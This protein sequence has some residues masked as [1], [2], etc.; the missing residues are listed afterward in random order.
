MAPRRRKLSKD[1]ERK[2]SLSQKEI[3]LILA[4]INDIIEDD[5]REEYSLSFAPIKI[6]IDKINSHYIQTGYTED[7][8][9]NFSLYLKYLKKFKSDYEI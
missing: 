1:F 8:E 3:E 9:K 4:K 6:I 5:I 2:V 7:S